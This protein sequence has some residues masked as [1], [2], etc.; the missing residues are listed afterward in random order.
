V[1]IIGGADSIGSHYI[2]AC[3]RFTIASLCFIDINENELTDLIRGLF[4]RLGEG[5]GVRYEIA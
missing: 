3:L 4:V 1:L 5:A 2:K